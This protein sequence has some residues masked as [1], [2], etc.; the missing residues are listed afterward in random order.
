MEVNKTEAKEMQCKLK[1]V[2]QKSLGLAVT[3]IFFLSCI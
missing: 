2:S 1:K 3:D